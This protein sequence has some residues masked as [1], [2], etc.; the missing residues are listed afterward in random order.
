VKFTLLFLLSASIILPIISF[1]EQ[2]TT[3]HNGSRYT[4]QRAADLVRNY[5]NSESSTEVLK[6][7]NYLNYYRS[8]YQAVAPAPVGFFESLSPKSQNFIAE[9]KKLAEKFVV[10]PEKMMPGASKLSAEGEKFYQKVIAQLKSLPEPTEPHIMGGF[11]K[12]P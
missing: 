4:I 8:W 12:K 2:T 11:P 5:K 3:P 6:T 1:E 10:T 9:I 7:T